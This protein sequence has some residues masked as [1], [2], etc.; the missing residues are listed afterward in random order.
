ML[1]CSGRFQELR[2]LLEPQASFPLPTLPP[3]FPSLP[4][5]PFSL[6]FTPSFRDFITK[7]KFGGINRPFLFAYISF[8]P[9]TF[10]S[11]SN[12]IFL[13]FLNW[14]PHHFLQ[15]RF[16]FT[17]NIQILIDLFIGGLIAKALTG[18]ECPI[19]VL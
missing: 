2:N 11:A 12:W 7:S 18:S 19:I 5:L 1:H 10:P 3:L 9:F 6:S 13:Q 14:L 8:P 17:K 15:Q 4:Y 16:F